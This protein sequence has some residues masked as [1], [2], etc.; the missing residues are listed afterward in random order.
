MRFFLI[1][2][3]LI[4]SLLHAGPNEITISIQPD[5]ALYGTPFSMTISDLEPEERAIIKARAFDG[6][7]II[8]VSTATFPDKPL[9]PAI[10]TSL[11]SWASFGP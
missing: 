9:Y 5:E 11:M 2:F 4:P 7:G 6:S 10:T 3:V 8:W 1:V